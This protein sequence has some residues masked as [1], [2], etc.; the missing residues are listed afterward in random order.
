VE[1]IDKM[2]LLFQ[3]ARM[4][5]AIICFMVVEAV[6]INDKISADD[7][8]DE[9]KGKPSIPHNFQADSKSEFISKVQMDES[10]QQSMQLL[11]NEIMDQMICSKTQGPITFDTFDLIFKTCERSMSGTDAWIS[12]RITDDYGKTC[13]VLNFN[14]HT[15]RGTTHSF[16]N[17]Q[18]T[19]GR[20]GRPKSIEFKG[21]SNAYCITEAM[22]IP[23]GSKTLFKIIVPGV[24]I[25]HNW[26][27]LPAEFGII[28][29]SV[30]MQTR[31]MFYDEGAKSEVCNIREEID[32]LN[33]RIDDLKGRMDARLGHI[34]ALSTRIDNIMDIISHIMIHKDID[35]DALWNQVGGLQN[36]KKPLSSKVDSFQNEIWQLKSSNKDLLDWEE[37]QT[38]QVSSL[39]KDITDL[40]AR[41]VIRCEMGSEKFPRHCSGES[42]GY[43]C[44]QKFHQAF[45][46]IPSVV[47]AVQ[48]FG[49]NINIGY[50]YKYWIAQVQSTTTH[51]DFKNYEDAVHVQ[52]MACGV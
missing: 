45:T 37:S 5:V 22:V 2:K 21:G 47:V 27:K 31:R 35:L 11:K 4:I 24:W 18:C 26:K 40:K 39:Q 12:V 51:Y 38:P 6:N 3:M 46:E 29:R 15:S 41:K 49:P 8:A 43:I 48:Q 42:R 19:S 32:K 30:A 1:K 44:R 10:M 34:Q 23:L 20:I 36:W 9:E 14:G 7:K 25:N 50:K 28:K 16:S 13:E 17:L 52:Y 33:S